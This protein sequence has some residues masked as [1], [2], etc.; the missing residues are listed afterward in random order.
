MAEAGTGI[1]EGEPNG[2]VHVLVVDD[3]VDYAELTATYLE[4]DPAFS[5][6]TEFGGQD[7]AGRLGAASLPDCVVSDH[8]MPGMNGLEFL[9]AV[10]DDHPELP[11]IL[12]TGKGNEEIASE[13]VSAGVTDYVKKG[14][15]E[16]YDVLANRVRN[17]VER[18]R[19]QQALREEK[20][21]L[22]QVLATTPGSIVCSRDGTIEYAT[23]RAARTLGT[24]RAYIVGARWNDP[25][26]W[27][28]SDYDGEPLDAADRPIT[29]AFEQCVAVTDVPVAIQKQD[30]DRLYL[31]VD[32]APLRTS[33][34]EDPDRV[35]ASFRDV[36]DQI[37]HERELADSRRKY[38]ALV[39]SLPDAV[40]LV[41]DETATVVEANATA[42]TLFECDR[43]AIIGRHVT[44]LHPRDEPER[45]RRFFEDGLPREPGAESTTRRFDDGT[46]VE[47]QTDT[48]ARVPV[49]IR[50]TVLELDD[51]T[52]VHGLFRDLSDEAERQRELERTR[53]VLEAVGD[54]T[55]ALDED[56]CFTYANDAM[57]EL[58]GYAVDELVGEHCS[59]VMG[60]AHVEEGTGLIRTLLRENRPRGM[61]RMTVERKDGEH[62]QVENH[63]ALLPSEGEFRGTAGIARDVTDRVEQERRLRESEQKYASVVQEA[64]DGVVIAQDGVLRFL[65]PKAC[66][67]LN[68]D[69]HELLGQPVQG[70][71]A[72]EDREKVADRLRRR[73]AGEDP[74]RRYEFMALAVDGEQI[75]IEFTASVVTYEGAPA[76]L[77]ICRDI[78]ERKQ[79]ERELEQY[80]TIVQTAPDG[81]FIVDEHGNYTGGNM[82][83]AELTGYT[84]QELMGKGVPELVEEGVF[85]PEVVPRYEATVRHLLSSSNDDEKG[86]FEFT[87]TRDGES[88]IYE[89]HVSLRP[90]DPEAGE[91]F[92][93]SIGVLRDVT[94]R[95][96]RQRELER[97]NERLED[98]TNV[99]G[100]DLRNPLNVAAGN[101]ELAR[102]S[103]DEAQFDRIE[104]AHERIE[105]I[106]DDLLTLAR[107]GQAVDDT[108]PVSIHELAQT[109]WGTVDTAAASLELGADIEFQADPGRIRQL[110]ENLY[111]NAVTHAGSDVTVTVDPLPEG[112]FVVADDGPGIPEDV[113]ESVFEPGFST[114][115]DGTGFGLAIVA[116]VAESHGWE[117]TVGAGEQGAR[118]EIRF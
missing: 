68:A 47:I 24:K 65:N 34:G 92:R 103:C 10:R 87:I 60:E 43:E 115:Q 29:R 15:P 79:R 76:V 102:A 85:G 74:E 105:E 69:E 16:Q 31:S 52:L 37:Q 21:L 91:T 75:P 112:G 17:A 63:I 104:D 64:N 99:I 84:Q 19:S 66:D 22:E 77:A 30:G 78:R 28:Y 110:L 25:E 56:G 96:Q 44:D 2:D 23:A 108:E 101:L 54:A 100:H 20:E 117:A 40:V 41:D 35:V 5:V 107:T 32:A 33:G 70:V 114:R 90:F 118:I 71:V 11:F 48:G 72:P 3:D 58:S 61:A 50:G 6:V 93:G 80:E 26:V 38:H 62:I 12:F 57:A 88:R 18:R 13:A 83:G 113:V 55:Y 95:K 106:L 7:A 111:A 27:R 1:Q 8:D 39:E 94:E 98:F 109:A 67:I 86:T 42:G 89:C 14:G 46:P 51:R 36:T 73:L 4:R 81:V 53:T 97:Q 116:D 59:L 45:Y 9:A 82:S 49:E